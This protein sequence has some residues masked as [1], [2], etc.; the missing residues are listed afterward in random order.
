M[1]EANRREGP[2]NDLLI[3]GPSAKPT[4]QNLLYLEQSVNTRNLGPFKE[5]RLFTEPF[6]N[7]MTISTD[8]NLTSL[9]FINF[10]GDK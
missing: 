4:L 9:N 6:V 3:G 8:E 5:T 10:E 7:Q 1:V 2:A